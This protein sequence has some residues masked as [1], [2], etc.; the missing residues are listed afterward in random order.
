[1][2]AI[3]EEQSFVFNKVRHSDGVEIELDGS[4]RL[5]WTN[6]TMKMTWRLYREDKERIIHF[7]NE[8][9]YVCDIR[10]AWK[11]INPWNVYQPKA[12]DT[13]L[14]IRAKH[15]TV[16]PEIRELFTTNVPFELHQPTLNWVLEQLNEPEQLSKL[17][18]LTAPARVLPKRCESRRDFK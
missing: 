3:G 8:T 1:M 15:T 16:K 4:Y 17:R 6:W 7:Y 18:A 14:N 13:A 12:G 10:G 11:K 9:M 2:S 5:T